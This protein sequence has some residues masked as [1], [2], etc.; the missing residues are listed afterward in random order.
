V[1]EDERE[2]PPAHVSRPSGP[3]EEDAVAVPQ[4]SAEW[5][6]VLRAGDVEVEGRLPWSSNY[7]FLVTVTCGEYRV[8]AVY[9]P[10]R[11]ERHLWDFGGELFRRE[12]AAYELSAALG[13]DLV[14]ETVLRLDAPLEEGSL[15]RFVDADFEQHYFSLLSEP[16]HDARL[17][18]LAGLD[19]FMNNA[20]RK[21]GHVLLDFEGAIWGI[22]NGLCFHAEPKLRTVMWDFAG[23][24]VPDVVIEAAALLSEAVPE[25]V[26]ALISEQE[27][28]ALRQRA[29]ALLRRPKFP[30]PGADHRSY[31]WPLV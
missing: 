8:R 10:G 4:T 6:E 1:P 11:G 17:R 20:D 5:L 29:R 15:Q 18:E 24:V 3:G 22:D 2:R 12:V 19:L 14:P 28:E 13:L 23:E 25:T 30:T 27:V 21:G 31:P 7:S 9:K 16:V 26:C